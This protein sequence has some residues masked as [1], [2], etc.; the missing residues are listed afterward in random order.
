MSRDESKYSTKK[1]DKD[2]QLKCKLMFSTLHGWGSRGS[3]P[4]PRRGHP[5]RG[6]AGSEPGGGHARSE[7][8]GGRARRSH[9][10]RRRELRTH[11]RGGGPADAGDWSLQ[12][13]RGS[14]RPAW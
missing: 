12:P 13:R 11:V 8:W 10:R 6:H 3:G 5:C 2:K 7:P 1:Q 14:K 4:E 9:L